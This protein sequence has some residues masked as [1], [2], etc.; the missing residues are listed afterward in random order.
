M[1]NNQAHRQNKNYGSSVF[2][3]R[4]M[5]AALYPLYRWS[6]RLCYGWRNFI[7]RALGAKLGEGFRIY[8]SSYIMYPWNFEAGD[9][10]TI[11]WGVRLYSLGKITIGDHVLISQGAHL[12]AGT[13]DHSKDNLPLVCD[14]V[15]IGSHCW[16]CADAF[17]G[18]NVTVGEGSLVAARAVVVKDVEAGS[19][20]GG[21][22]ARK[23][24]EWKPTSA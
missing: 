7:L 5:W 14:P 8:P 22:P 17:I 24:G 11:S 21:N 3:K 4:L 19:I 23:I 10:V 18:P 12:C 13:H 6:P 16:L 1:F 20:V 2:A 9:W 15:T